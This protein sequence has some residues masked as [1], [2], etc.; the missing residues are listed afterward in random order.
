MQPWGV[1]LLYYAR[2]EK[3]ALEEMGV[4]L[5]TELEQFV[6]RC[7]VVTINLPLTDKTR[8]M[9]NKDVISKMKKVSRV[10]AVLRLGEV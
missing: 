10:N 6:S 9:F 5:V 3:P 1:E 4:E 7:D 2:R 8:G